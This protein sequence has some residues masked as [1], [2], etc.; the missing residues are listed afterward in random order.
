MNAENFYFIPK[1]VITG[2]S[3]HRNLKAQGAYSWIDLDADVRF[4]T[5]RF[6]KKGILYAAKFESVT[7]GYKPT[8]QSDAAEQFRKTVLDAVNELDNEPVGGFRILAWGANPYGYPDSHP[9]ADSVILHDP[10]G[11]STAV[12]KNQFFKTLR[13][14][15]GVGAGCVLAGEYIYGWDSGTKE[16]ALIPVGCE[17]YSEWTRLTEE[18]LN[19]KIPCLSKKD[20]AV[21]GVYR[22]KN[23]LLGDWM[24]MGIS[25]TYSAK[26]HL[27][28]FDSGEYDIE[29]SVVEDKDDWMYSSYGM[30]WGTSKSRMVFRR[31]SKRQIGDRPYMA[32]ISINGIFEQTPVLDGIYPA[33][34]YEKIRDEMGSSLAFQRLDLKRGVQGYEPLPESDFA[35]CLNRGFEK[36]N[37][38]DGFSCTAFPAKDMFDCVFRTQSGRWVKIGLSGRESRIKDIESGYLSIENRISDKYVYDHVKPAYPVLF[39]ENGQKV[40]PAVSTIFIPDEIRKAAQ[41]IWLW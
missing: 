27:N 2:R 34:L 37:E 30:M 26:C 28:A 41:A 36:K 20:L 15:E 33:G 9:S 21:G 10:R 14:S 18:S 19:R 35:L 17:E 4:I 24:Y 39:Y 12:T 16:L 25:D 8:T 6:M 23:P 32:K 29:T 7:G 5:C 3:K 1:I 38:F 11:F 13:F 22:H 40:P 31:V